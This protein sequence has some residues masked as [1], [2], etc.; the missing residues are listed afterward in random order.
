MPD[1][2]PGFH[3]A[4]LRVTFD[5]FAKERSV[6][7]TDPMHPSDFLIE[8]GRT[9]TL[10][11]LPTV[12]EHPEGKAAA[13]V[14]TQR[15]VAELQDLQQK[16]W[17]QHERRVLVVLQARDA[18]GKDG[19]VRHVFG[20]LNPQSVKVTSFSQPTAPELAHD[21]LWRVHARV[22][23]DG[24]LGIFNRSHYEDVLIARV[25]DL[26]PRAQWKKRFRQICDFERMLTEE[27]T[28][29]VK[30]FLHISKEEQR[31]RLQ[32]RVDDPAKHWKYTPA[33]LADRALWDDYG[34]AHEEMLEKTST[35][36][37][38]WSIVP[39][40]DKWYRNLVIATVMVHTMRGLNLEF[41]PGDPTLEHVV[42]I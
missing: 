5:Q 27:G 35:E 2:A 18:G 24:Q 20:H 1:V 37:A 41:P 17:A 32:A 25:H 40:D 9:V 29:I 7:Q 34:L 10:D 14:E 13:L 26:V 31:K 19:T 22:P 16:L 15:L 8:P 39:A 30:F 6:R 21:Y 42:V 28:T 12:A 33:D 4:E 36:Y 23:E 3:D 11:E 38:P